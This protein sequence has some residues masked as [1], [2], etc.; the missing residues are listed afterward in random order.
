[1]TRIGADIEVLEPP[2]LRSRMAEQARR[3]ADLYGV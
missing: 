1:M 2:E 3:L